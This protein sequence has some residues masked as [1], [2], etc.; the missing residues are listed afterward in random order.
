MKRDIL[1]YLGNKIGELELPDG[2]A[3]SVWATKLSAYATPP[4]DPVKAAVEKTIDDR[5]LYCQDLIQRFKYKNL[6]ENI[7]AVQAMYLHHKMRAIN[8]TFYGVPMTL[9][10]M[11]L[12]ISGDVEIACLALMNMTPD[13]MTAPYHWLN[14]ARVNWL[15]ADMKGYLGWV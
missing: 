10:L 1:D 7:N 3:E 8:I 9:D 6:T 15:V 2:T 13:D 12:V 4:P 11:N 14:A 5:V